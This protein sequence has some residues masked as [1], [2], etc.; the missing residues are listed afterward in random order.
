MAQHGERFE[1]TLLHNFM[2]N[3]MDF[4]DGD[5]TAPKGD[6]VM[7]FQIALASS[8]SGK[9]AS[10]ILAANLYGARYRNMQKKIA[11]EP[12]CHLPPL[13]INMSKEDMI[14]FA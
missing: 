10:E 12:T 9:K 11:K 5:L 14:K 4:M 3:Y 7:N 13:L 8:G 1:H 2:M 6:R